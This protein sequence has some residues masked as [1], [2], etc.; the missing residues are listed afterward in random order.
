VENLAALVQEIQ[1]MKRVQVHNRKF[2][3]TKP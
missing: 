3:S 2:S 1:S